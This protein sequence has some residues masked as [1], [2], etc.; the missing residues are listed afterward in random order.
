[1]LVRFAV[2]NYLSFDKK[3]ELSMV[4][5]NDDMLL[6]NVCEVPDS[7]IK[8][9]GE[10]SLGRY[11]KSA[12]IYGANA[13]GKSNLLIALFFMKSFIQKSAQ[14]L[15]PEKKTGTIPFKLKKENQNQPSEFEIEII[16]N[17]IRYFYS[18]A[19]DNKQVIEEKLNSF[20]FN[21]PRMIF[22]RTFKNGKNDIVF[23]SDF[24]TTDAEKDLLTKMVP[25]NSLFLSFAAKHN[26]EISKLIYDWFVNK[27]QFIPG[28]RNE[29]IFLFTCKK[30]KEVEFKNR[31]LGIIQNADIDIR[32]F[33][34]TENVVEMPDSIFR[35]MNEL[36]KE[37]KIDQVI[38]KKVRIDKVYT[39]HHMLDEP[40][41]EIEF[42]FDIESDG[43][44]RLFELLGP[45][46]C[47]LND[48]NVIVID[49][50]ESSM[51]PNL[52]AM[53]LKYFHKN[54]DPSNRAQLIFA[55]HSAN[56]LNRNLLRRDQIWFTD[57]KKGY[58]E[59]YSLW[60]FTP[61][62]RKKGPFDKWYLE[63]RFGGVPYIDY[64]SLGLEDPNG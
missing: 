2:Q 39:K 9:T 46:I 26:N 27:L 13:S 45:M 24:G 23:G 47:S 60:D 6:E 18:F 29:G 38:E 33:R 32:D 53:L 48:G 62:P 20:P 35:L 58:T 51:H 7:L 3:M 42:P 59:L 4:A 64:E 54:S 40:E 55:T 14:G 1:M 21:K 25:N 11:L 22:H 37:D 15:P 49:E 57:K 19:A 10:V 52:V 12:A 28:T 44:K 5:S 43:T 30:S 17:N 36:Y 50:I 8:K 61:I 31:I 16:L 41:K 34:T 63:G 56:L